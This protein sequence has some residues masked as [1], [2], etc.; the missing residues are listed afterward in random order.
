MNVLDIERA[1]VTTVARSG[2]R[3]AF[4]DAVPD[5]VASDIIVEPVTSVTLDVAAHLLGKS[6]AL[7]RVALV[8]G[9]LRLT[10]ASVEA[11]YL[12]A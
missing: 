7:V 11:L 2:S 4:A 9:D 5:A 8:R 12:D 10:A 3:I 6:P 1:N